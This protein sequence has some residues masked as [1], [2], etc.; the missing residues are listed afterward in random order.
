MLCNYAGDIKSGHIHSSHIISWMLAPFLCLRLM[1]SSVF[2]VVVQENCRALAVFRA[3]LSFSSGTLCG[4]AGMI[5]SDVGH[6]FGSAVLIEMS[7][8]VFSN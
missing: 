1:A 8:T 3:N 2:T 5:W 7:L 6:I 4:N